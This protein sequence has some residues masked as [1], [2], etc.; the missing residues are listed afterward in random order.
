MQ[1]KTLMTL[2]EIKDALSDR[3]IR[4]VSAACG[5]KY[6]TVLGVANGKNTNPSYE[7][8]KALVE[9]LAK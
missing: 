6:Q 3:N 7:T 1:S 9:Y 2:E 4:A 5:L 8:Y